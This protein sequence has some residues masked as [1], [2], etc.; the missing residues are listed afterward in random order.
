MRKIRTIAFLLSLTLSCLPA[1]A[2]DIPGGELD[3]IFYRSRVALV[4]E[5]M[6]LFNFTQ[7]RENED[8]ASLDGKRLHLLN[9]F[10]KERFRSAQDTSFLQA[11]S[12]VDRVLEDSVRLSIADSCWFA[13]AKCVGK[14]AGK[15]V[16]VDLTLRIQ[17][18]GPELYSWIIA[19]AEGELLSLTPP[20]YSRKYSIDPVEH[21]IRFMALSRITSSDRP[22]ILNY[23]PAGW[24]PDETSVFFALVYAGALTLDYVDTLEFVYGQVPGY[25]F[26]IRYFERDETTN[27]GWL[28]DSWEE[29]DV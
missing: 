19:G 5:F 1:R 14:Y 13:H 7:L 8:T 15:D 25:V 20:V 22:A 12:F 3:G 29:V 21:D 27:S 28:I 9:L 10:N 17:E 11:L 23:A 16:P 18:W 2:Q 26:T 4:D 24:H 6:D